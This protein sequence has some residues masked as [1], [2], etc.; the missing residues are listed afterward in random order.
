MVPSAIVLES[1]T[2]SLLF[3]PFLLSGWA[4]M[5]VGSELIVSGP[6]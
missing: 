1:T 3:T 4:R 2:S 5:T 6:F